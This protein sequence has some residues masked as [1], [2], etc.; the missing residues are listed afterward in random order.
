MLAVLQILCAIF[1]AV[2]SS[3]FIREYLTTRQLGDRVRNQNIIAAALGFS[4]AAITLL[5]SFIFL[6]GVL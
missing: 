6:M 2:N 1:C 4:I 5:W 3:A